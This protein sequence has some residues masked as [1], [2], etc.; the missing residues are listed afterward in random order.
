MNRNRN[1]K[2]D[3][4][5]PHIPTLKLRKKKRRKDKDVRCQ[6][7]I[8]NRNKNTRHSKKIRNI[9]SKNVPRQQPENKNENETKTQ[10]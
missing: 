8:N 6:F 10:E 5:V 2:H 3:I 4:Y 7:D 9:E 1:R